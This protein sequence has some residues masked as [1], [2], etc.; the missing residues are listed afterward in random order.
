[1]IVNGT[2]VPFRY[3]FGTTGSGRRYDVQPHHLVRAP[4]TVTAGGA[5]L[6]LYPARGGGTAGALLLHVPE[7]RPLF[8]RGAFRPYLGAP[9]VAEGSAEGLFET[10]ALIRSL[11]ARV[12]VHGH[13]PL[14][15][16]FTVKALPAIEPALRE[17]HQRVRTAVGD[18]RTLADIL[19]DNILP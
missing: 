4:E 12:L 3:F 18:G 9:F 6:V 16:I 17:L 15:D 11:Q 13:P 10:M 8:V 7:R 5:R 19:H 14:T 2:G 1:R